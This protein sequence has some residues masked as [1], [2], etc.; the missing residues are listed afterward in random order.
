MSFQA[1]DWFSWFYCICPAHN[2]DLR[3]QWCLISENSQKVNTEKKNQSDAM[4]KSNIQWRRYSRL[5]RYRWFDRSPVDTTVFYL[6]HKFFFFFFLNKSPI[7]A[8]TERWFK[9]SLKND[10]KSRISNNTRFRAESTGEYVLR[11]RDCMSDRNSKTC[12]TVNAQNCQYFRN[13]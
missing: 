12:K 11:K 7:N 8:P 9:C 6:K 13:N 5:L 10:D 3:Y 4:K 2:N 1:A